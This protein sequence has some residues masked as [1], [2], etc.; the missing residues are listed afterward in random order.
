MMILLAPLVIY[1]LEKRGKRCYFFIIGFVLIMA[2]YYLF[3]HIHEA[4]A[5]EKCFESI[6]PMINLAIGEAFVL[7]TAFASF[8]YVVP[9]RYF[10]MAFGLLLACSNLAFVIS[11]FIVGQVLDA[12]HEVRVEFH[13]V[14]LTLLTFSII[15]LAISLYLNYEDEKSRGILNA[16]IVRDEDTACNESETSKTL[17]Q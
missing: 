4:S 8:P 7:I 6:V 2:S 9:E 10:T 1:A 17:T 14:Y 11:A 12:S 3:Y 16:V 15:G 5:G 13:S